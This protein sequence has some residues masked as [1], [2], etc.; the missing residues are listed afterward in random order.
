MGC[1]TDAFL[2]IGTPISDTDLF[3]TT[4]P[5]G[6]GHR[7]RPGARFCS[8]CGAE[9]PKPL[10]TW[11]TPQ[12][13]D[14]GWN[15]QDW[16]VELGH[17]A[18]LHIGIIIE[19]GDSGEMFF[20]RVLRETG[21]LMEGGN[22]DYSAAVSLSTITTIRDEIRQYLNNLGLYDLASQVDVRLVGY[23]SC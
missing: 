8:T 20:G 7:N 11:R 22:R 16:Q 19:T 10:H 13:A 6:C 12:L 9:I 5:K 4:T 14:T 18:P 23:C 3:T 17:P 21:D 1:S 2:I 15:P